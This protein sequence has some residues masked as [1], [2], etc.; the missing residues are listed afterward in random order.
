[1]KELENIA[2]SMEREK[3]E[4]KMGQIGHKTSIVI[5]KKG[6]I[7][8]HVEEKKEKEVNKAHGLILPLE[9]SID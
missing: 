5:M 7:S 4:E 8:E 3:N 9:K 6:K 2:E 1:L